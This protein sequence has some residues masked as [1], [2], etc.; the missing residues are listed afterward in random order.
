MV[1]QAMQDTVAGGPLPDHR[2]ELA[3]HLPADVVERSEGAGG[4]QIVAAAPQDLRPGR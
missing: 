1:Q 4:H 3:A 2:P